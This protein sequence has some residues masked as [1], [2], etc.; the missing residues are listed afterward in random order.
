[1]KAPFSRKAAQKAFSGHAG[2]LGWLLQLHWQRYGCVGTQHEIKCTY[3]LLVLGLMWLV[4]RYTLIKQQ[5]RSTLIYQKDSKRD[6]S[7][8]K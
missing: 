5:L 4:T 7:E 3:Q 8:R 1:M 2:E 6:C